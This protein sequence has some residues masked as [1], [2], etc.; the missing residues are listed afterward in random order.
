[1][2]LFDENKRFYKGNLHTHTKNSDGR[3]TPDEAKELYCSNGYDFLTLTDH[4]KITA[5]K[6]EM[7][8]NMLVLP[9]VELDYWLH[10]QVVHIVGVNPDVS[11]L[12]NV[13]KGQSVLKG[14]REI[15]KAGGRAILAHP[16]WSLNTPEVIA[17]LAKECAAAEIFNSLSRFP[18]NADRAD[19]TLLLDIVAAQGTLINTVADD[20][21]HFYVGEECGGF[22]MA[23]MDDLDAVSVN[24]ALDKGSYYSSMGPL[25][26]QVEIVG[27]EIHV[28]C[29]AVQGIVFH[30]NLP[31]VKDRSRSG[32][33]SDTDGNG[34]LTSATYTIQPDD[35]YVRIM[36]IGADGKRAWVN[37]ISVR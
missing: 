36:L 14:I 31:W 3:R 29:S 24:R 25:V 33:N 16:A 26:H 34:L 4:W 37:P 13:S 22:I 18:Y 6:P 20:D 8:R 35:T 21:T 12:D 28:D 32:L 17:S 1:M 11:L 23:Q 9:G 10:N 30:S 5:P 19:S 27:N 7:Y 15:K 2:K